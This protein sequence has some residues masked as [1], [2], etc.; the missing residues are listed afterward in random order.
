MKNGIVYNCR[1][2][3]RYILDDDG[4][5]QINCIGPFNPYLM[6]PEYKPYTKEEKD[7][8]AKWRK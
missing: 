4:G 6:L 3:G 2:Y 7:K 8:W 1:D 5:Y